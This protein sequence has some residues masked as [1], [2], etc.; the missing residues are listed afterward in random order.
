VQRWLWSARPNNA[1]H[2]LDLTANHN[3]SAERRSNRPIIPVLKLM[4]SDIR[5]SS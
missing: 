2:W 3:H 5:G 1:Q 4:K